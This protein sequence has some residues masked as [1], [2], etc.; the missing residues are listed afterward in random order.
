LHVNRGTFSVDGV[1]GKAALNYDIA[2]LRYLYMYVPGIGVAVVSTTPFAGASEQKNA[3]NGASLVVNVEDH[4]LELASDNT[5]L[6]KKPESAY[7]KIDRAYSLPSSFPVFG[8][9]TLRV[10]PYAWP[11]A[12]PNALLADTVAPPPLPKS[13]QPALANPN[14]PA[15]Q[16]RLPPPAPVK[17]KPQAVMPCL[18][19]AQ[20]QA[21]GDGKGVE[22]KMNYGR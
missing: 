15:G 7:V 6:S 22:D 20:M 10:A 11:G 2:D 8:Y 18:T 4:K 17:G 19:Q 16:S 5:L 14:C 12:K 1:V 13:L 9:G 21:A 3:F